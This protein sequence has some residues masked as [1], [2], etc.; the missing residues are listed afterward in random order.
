MTVIQTEQEGIQRDLNSKAL[1]VSDTKELNSWKQQ[2][3]LITRIT[4]LE[5][6]LEEVK[7]KL[8]ELTELLNRI[9]KNV[10]RTY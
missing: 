7:S 6:E 4:K 2:K 10:T 1:I 8:S 5:L 3:K 9:G